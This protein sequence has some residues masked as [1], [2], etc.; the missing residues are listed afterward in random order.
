MKRDLCQMGA[1]AMA[2]THNSHTMTTVP[3]SLQ[4]ARNKCPLTRQFQQN[5]QN[6]VKS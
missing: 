1:L 6:Q 2:I 3:V 5:G 4:I